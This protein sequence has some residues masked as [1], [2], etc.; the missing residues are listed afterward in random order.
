MDNNNDRLTRRKFNKGVSFL[1]A[2][3]I[4]GGGA[5][6]TAVGEESKVTVSPNREILLE[7]VEKIYS[8][9]RWNGR[10]EVELWKGRYY[11]GFVSAAEH[12]SPDSKIVI[13]RSE[14]GEPR[15]W[16]DLKTIVETDDDDMEIHFLSTPNR[17]FA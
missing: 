7:R 2:G 3:G 9:G 15:K 16:G 10:P 11:L 5:L 6:K 12:E 17:L 8:D 14:G 4:A 1:V 13:M